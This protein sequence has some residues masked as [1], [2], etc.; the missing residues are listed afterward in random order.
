MDGVYEN[1]FPYQIESI[2]IAE[3]YISSKSKNNCLIKLPTGTGK[4]GVMAVIANQ[5]YGNVLIIVPNAT[6]PEQTAKEI[7]KGFWTNIRF[8][9]T[10]IKKVNILK[11]GKYSLDINN[12][13]NEIFIITIQ[14]LL[15]IHETDKSRFKQ[16]KECISLVLYDEGHREPA[17]EWS[18][19]SRELDKKTILFTATP[20]RNDNNILKIDNKFTYK[21]SMVDAI[22]EG[23]VKKP[24]F[25]AIPNDIFTNDNKLVE[26]VLNTIKQKE[27][28]VLIRCNNRNQI[29]FLTEELNKNMF[30]TIGCHS[31]FDN[32]EYLFNTGKKVL[33]DNDAYPVLIHCD[34]L[35][36]GVNIPQLNI[37]FLLAEFNNMKTTIQQ[38]GRILRPTSGNKAYIYISERSYNEISNQWD[39]YL[40]SELDE[41]NYLYIDGKFRKKFFLENCEEIYKAISFKRQ[42]NIYISEN[43]IFKKIQDSIEE[44][45]NRVGNLESFQTSI[46][47]EENLWV[48]CYQ[49]KEPSKILLDSYYFDCSLEYISIVEIKN[50]NQYYYF[51]YNSRRYAFPS[52]V[53]NIKLIDRNSIFK[54][55]PEGSDIRN[56]K[57]TSTSNTKIGPRT[58]ELDGISLNAIP[59]SLAE[60]LSFCRCATGYYSEDEH[61]I[62]RYLSSLTSKISEKRDCTYLEYVNWCKQI[63]C[64]LNHSKQN[65]FF[66]RFALISDTPRT[67][68]TSVLIDFIEVKK[69]NGQ[70]IFVES[71]FCKIENGEFVFMIE[72]KTKRGTVATDQKS[73]KTIL[74]INDL[75]EY[76]VEEKVPLG[77]FLQKN[78]FHIYFANEQIVY[79]H[80][81]YFK[82]N[83]KFTY[84][85]IEGFGLWKNIIAID[86]L[87]NCKSEKLGENPK[88][89]FKNRWPSDS[90]FGTI[91][92][93]IETNPT[94][95]N[96]DYLICDDLN[97]EIADFIALSTAEKKII[98]IH[99]KYG[100]ERLSASAFQDVCGQAVKNIEYLISTTP[101]T[102]THLQKHISIWKSEWSL[103]KDKKVYS[104]ERCVKGDADGFVVE[105]KK[106]LQDANALKEVWLVTSGLS[107]SALQVELLKKDNQVEQFH[108]LMFILHS[109]QDSLSQAGVAMKIFC[110]N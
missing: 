55:I 88:N 54:L 25:I 86:N 44:Q 96:I 98:L 70:A 7:A 94:Y 69:N 101:E 67:S 83:I 2:S 47:E 6:L 37:L 71:Q 84:N 68:P 35:I 21:Y 110:K 76:W 4:T 29:G 48:L 56:T 107:K 45:I 74:K 39:L 62:I 33:K 64:E 93:E 66:N 87:E 3:R 105:Y 59:G 57:Y 79:Y 34:M 24:E 15:S 109:T 108:Q 38:I 16:I 43:P 82:P 85:S 72:S 14:T 75:E 81:L 90:V 27:G 100:N 26:F 28:K 50:N 102:L 19:A 60:R 65:L 92:K 5:F 51:Y 61:K 77:K 40:K 20:Y 49:R 23:Y 58:K 91:V 12:K 99:C 9:P 73:G 95:D 89:T 18:A 11:G 36:E 42:A 97:Y 78:K 106:I 80:G 1:L 8:T 31:E 32:S 13:M 103:S 41:E 10:K 63:V 17:E 30:P 104:T 22:K 46:Y 53:D 52:E